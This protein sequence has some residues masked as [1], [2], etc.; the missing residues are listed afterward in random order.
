MSRGSALVP[1]SFRDGSAP[2]MKSDWCMTICSY[3]A[4]FVAI[5]RYLDWCLTFIYSLKCAGSIDV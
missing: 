1:A 2:T 5:V 3:V 4:L